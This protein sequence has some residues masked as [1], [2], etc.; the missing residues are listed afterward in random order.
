MRSLPVSSE[1]CTREGEG[2]L[3]P[4]NTQPGQEKVLGHALK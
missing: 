4:E 2:R 1:G 3:S